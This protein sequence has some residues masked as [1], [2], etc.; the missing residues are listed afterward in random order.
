MPKINEIIG[1]HANAIQKKDMKWS[2][3]FHEDWT[4]AD[5]SYII[6]ILI[7]RIHIE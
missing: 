7:P 4:V 3:R 2:A 1:C 5:S 6:F